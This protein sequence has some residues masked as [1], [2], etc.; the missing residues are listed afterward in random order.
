MSSVRVFWRKAGDPAIA[1]Y[2]IFRAESQQ[3]PFWL[4]ATIPA[5]V[6]G[7]N[8]DSNLDRFFYDD[9]A[10][11]LD[12]FYQVNALNAFTQVI[13]QS[14]PFTPSA[15]QDTAL[16]NRAR[17]DHDYGGVDALRYLAP[18]GTPIP[19]AEI[20]IYLQPDYAQGRTTTPYAIL[21]TRDDGR[22][23]TPAYLPVGANYVI[24]FFKPSGYG[25]DIITITV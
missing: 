25:P 8:F 6:T 5:D 11:A 22:W 1:N 24:Q 12:A 18:G 9:S 10:G 16:A 23:V 4:L 21:M 3:G 14:A 7:A 20:R 15:I 2:Q 17:V 13:A 19:Q